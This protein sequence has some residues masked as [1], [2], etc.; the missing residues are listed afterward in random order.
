MGSRRF[1]HPRG[2]MARTR[3]YTSKMDVDGPDDEED[4][5]P[6]LSPDDRL[7]RH[8]SELPTQPAGDA[9]RQ[10]RI[11]TVAI[12]SGVAGALASLG[13]VSALGGFDK[14]RPG[15]AAIER[16]VVNASPAQLPSGTTDVPQ[17]AERFR[18]AIVQLRVTGGGKSSSGS[19]VILRSDGH[20]L[21]N[22]H[23]VENASDVIVVMADGSEHVASVVGSDKE[24][25]VAV[26]HL[27]KPVD[28]LVTAP[29]GSAV[30]LQVG[31][32]AIAIGSPL[33]LAGGPSVSVG[34][35]SALGRQV[36]SQ[37]GQVLFDMIQTDAPIAPGSSGGAL[38]DAEGSVVGITTA[39]A[40]SNV[41]AEGLGFATPIDVARDV[42]NQLIS[43]G[44]ASH[45][46]LG[47]LGEDISSERAADLKLEGGA[48]VKEVVE[49]SPADAAG[50]EAG[51]VISS[52]GGQEVRSMSA[53]VVAM[54]KFDPGDE[55]S[56]TYFRGKEKLS[57]KL[58]LA[59]R[60][61]TD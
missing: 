1:E 41:G 17:I 45:A 13:L 38:L 6:W 26:V 53:L 35:V 27:D 15:P 16:E 5:P 11:W 20:I 47:V 22:A 55:V 14:V 24:T 21:T 48:Q 7:W 4:P 37:E 60:P 50:I 33:G 42:A 12:V 56:L 40:I 3:P 30:E 49:G 43:D 25:D 39:I 18:P 32:T 51:D 46:W 52:V 61:G 44:K 10:P 58:T 59:E 54:R 8:P 2:G 36:T 34:V 29:L 31:Q 19:G 23:V 9:A 57:K 28:D